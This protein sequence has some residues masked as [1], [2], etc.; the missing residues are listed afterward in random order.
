MGWELALI[1]VV[2]ITV[3]RRLAQCLTD[4][5]AIYA[6][7]KMLLNAKYYKMLKKSLQTPASWIQGE[8][9]EFT[10]GYEYVKADV[11]TQPIRRQSSG[12]RHHTLWLEQQQNS[13]G[14]ESFSETL[15]AIKQ[16]T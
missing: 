1:L 6:M 10:I 12:T 3:H 7:G 16:T 4:N 2:Y 8:V 11:G 14:R 15:G 5:Q 13:W 9:H